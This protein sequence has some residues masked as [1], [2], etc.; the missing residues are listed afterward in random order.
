MGVTAFLLSFCVQMQFL[1]ILKF[2]LEGLDRVIF[3][4]VVD[5]IKI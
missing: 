2:E 5:C 3:V 1:N 4:E